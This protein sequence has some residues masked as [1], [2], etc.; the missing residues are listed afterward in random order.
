MLFILVLL[1]FA[2][3]ANAQ[4]KISI[5]AGNNGEMQCNA[6]LSSGNFSYY[7][8]VFT[9]NKGKN[10]IDNIT[11]FPVKLEADQ[12]RHQYTVKGWAWV[13]QSG[14]SLMR[15]RK[16]DAGEFVIIARD[17]CGNA[18][19]TPTTPVLIIS[20]PIQPT[21]A[22][23]IVA[24]GPNCVVCPPIVQTLPA[25]VTKSR[26]GRGC[27]TGIVIGAALLGFAAS[28]GGGDNNPSKKPP[29]VITLPCNPCS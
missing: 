7:V 22:Q 2:V 29:V 21:L 25:V 24:T 19:E 6:A 9:G 1:A 23:A 13:V 14:G 18:D 4:T 11:I 8:P 20:T 10:P 28:Q 12:C 16:N 5:F 15:A 26:C 3:S 27:K 17:D